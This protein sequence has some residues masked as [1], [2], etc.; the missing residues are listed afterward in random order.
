MSR[1]KNRRWLVIP[2][3][4]IDDI[5]FS[6]VLESNVDSLR[7]SIDGTKTFVKYEVDI[8]DEDFE[9]EY[10]HP[11]TSE[12]ESYI[13]KAGVYGRP[14]IYSEDY[15]EYNHE[16]ILALLSTEEWVTNEIEE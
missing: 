10:I 8:V 3:E 7:R 9:T 15:T 4:K 14:D 5:N 11:Q 2:I 12:E 1:F 6:Q 13:T 16:N